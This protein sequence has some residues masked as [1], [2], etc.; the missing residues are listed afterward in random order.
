MPRM[1]TRTF[2]VLM[3]LDPAL[4]ALAGLMLSR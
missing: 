1:P 2:G 3:S 4:G